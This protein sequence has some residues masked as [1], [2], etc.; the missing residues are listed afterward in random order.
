MN[1]PIPAAL[2]IL[3][4]SPLRANHAA[5]QAGRKQIL[6]WALGSYARGSSRKPMARILEPE[7]LSSWRV[8]KSSKN[9]SLFRQSRLNQDGAAQRKPVQ[10]YS[11]LTVAGGHAHGCNALSVL[12]GEALGSIRCGSVTFLRHLSAKMLG[13]TKRQAP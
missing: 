12:I 3:L 5:Q 6:L 2:L 7:L 9:W 10:V 1:T 13:N 11:P 8:P 4:C